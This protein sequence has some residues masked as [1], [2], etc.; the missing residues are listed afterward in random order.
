MLPHTIAGIVILC[1][2]IA[3]TGLFVAVGLLGNTHDGKIVRKDDTRSTKGNRHYYVQYQYEVDGGHYSG[4]VKVSK[5][6]YDDVREG[7]AI[8]VRAWDAMPDSGQWPRVP[9]HWPIEDLG[10]KW[11]FAVF[12]NGI[13]SVFLWLMYVRPWRQ[14]QLVRFG[15]LTKGIIREVKTHMNKGTKNYVIC[16][17][18]AAPS[19]DERPGQVYAGKLTSIAKSAQL[20][21]AGDV[22]TVLYY[23][24]KPWR[25]VLYAYSDY[26]VVTET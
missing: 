11:F 22:P 21:A 7:D 19:T 20:A 14:R 9:G 2:A 17:D 3:S 6:H 15:I 10:G 24:H 18:Y 25:S 13:L 4:E 23:P 16:Y 8:T 12:W 1:V 26:R 5:E